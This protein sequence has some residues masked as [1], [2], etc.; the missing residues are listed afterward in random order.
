MQIF[1]ERLYAKVYP[2]QYVKSLSKVDS[3]F[4]LS[5][6]ERHLFT[7]GVDAG[8]SIRIFNTLLE[9]TILTRVLTEEDMLRK[10][11]QQGQFN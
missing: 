8:Y 11:E 7:N 5:P 1:T 9:M 6:G 4:T 3:I 2:S 10:F